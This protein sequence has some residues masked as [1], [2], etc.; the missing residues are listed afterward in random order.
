MKAFRC[1]SV[2]AVLLAAG[3][4]VRAALWCESVIGLLLNA[5]LTMTVVLVIWLASRMLGRKHADDAHQSTTDDMPARPEQATA[6]SVAVEAAANDTDAAARHCLQ[7]LLPLIGALRRSAQSS[8]SAMDEASHIARESGTLM[9]QGSSNTREAALA[10]ERLTSFAQNSSSIFSNLYAQSAAIGP[11][12]ETMQAIARQTNLLSVNATIEAAHAREAGRGF[13]V[14]AAEVRKLAERSAEASREIGA[15]A[16]A[17]SESASEAMHG[18]EDVIEHAQAGK[19]RADEVMSSM[20][21]MS[22]MAKSR[23]L[24]MAKVRDGLVNL[25]E[26]SQKLA[27]RTEDIAV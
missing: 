19:E 13:A 22:E 14:V 27:A 18:I 4:L 10:I 2:L 20:S 6:A 5:A 8:V 17:L 16:S 3:C 11:I 15:I 7:S 9:D 1:A 24:A 26:L 23:A 21:Q 25:D 12:V